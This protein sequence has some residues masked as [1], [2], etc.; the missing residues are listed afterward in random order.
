MENSKSLEGKDL[1]TNSLY[2][3]MQFI[4]WTMNCSIY[5]FASMFFLYN[6]FQNKQIGLIL[7]IANIISIIMQPYISQIVVIKMRIPIKR[8]IMILTTFLCGCLLLLLF[9][10]NSN[11]GILLAVLYCISLIVVLTLQPFINSLGF[12]YI[13]NGMNINFGISR[14]AGSLSFALTSYAVGMLL[15]RF[16]P[17]ALPVFVL[18]SSVLLFLPLI[19]LPKTSAVVD[20]AEEKS[21]VKISSLFKKYPFLVYLT[22]GFSLLF[23][24]HTIIS[25]FITQIILSVGGNS[26]NIGVALMIAGFCELPAMIF[27]SK[28]VKIKSSAFWVNIS[29]IF[30]LVRSVA[31]IFASSVLLIQSTQALQAISFAL[32]IPASAYLLN[33]KMD[34][35]DSVFGQTLLTATMTLGGIVGNILG[36]VLLDSIGMNY[37]LI[38]GAITAGLGF[39]ATN[40]GIR[41]IDN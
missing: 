25:T 29:A 20:E 34:H 26:E 14:G 16:T 27:F 36:G 33:E 12:E 28:L 41:K 15:A 4:Y 18:V 35:A 6:N 11:V 37:L 3:F 22:L 19:L 40:V 31:I 24:F 30:F 10:T 39:L 38:F 32:F 5:S 17:N 2:T 9:L 1:K 13:N 8:T 23:V 7:A 21:N